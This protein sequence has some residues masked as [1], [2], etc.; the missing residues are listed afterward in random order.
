MESVGGWAV[1]SRRETANVSPPTAYFSP[2][3]RGEGARRA[4]EGFLSRQ[5][6]ET[7]VHQLE[8][9]PAPKVVMPPFGR[10]RFEAVPGH[11]LAKNGAIRAHIVGQILECVRGP[12]SEVV[13][14]SGHGQFPAGFQID[15]REI[16]SRTAI[17]S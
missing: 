4:D 6:F 15:Q 12:R 17:V 11:H 2:P 14:R 9:L 7:D 5:L 10:E 8:P 16:D 13:V 3:Q 1:G